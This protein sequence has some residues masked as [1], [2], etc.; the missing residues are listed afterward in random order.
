[1]CTMCFSQGISQTSYCDCCRSLGGIQPL[2]EL[3]SNE[4]TEVH[5]NACGALQ[6]LSFGKAN[7]E[8]KVSKVW[9]ATGV[10]REGK[11]SVFPI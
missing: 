6:N 10:V 3:L 4:L 7:D 8:N 11:F 2:I 1:M 5:R 9:I